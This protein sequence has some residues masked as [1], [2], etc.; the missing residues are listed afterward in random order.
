M[1][2]AQM[3]YLKM[4]LRKRDKRNNP[5]E[6]ENEHNL[7]EEKKE[8]GFSQLYGKMKPASPQ[9]EYPRDYPV[10]N[11]T[12]QTEALYQEFKKTGKISGQNT[13]FPFRNNF[14]YEQFTK[15]LK[16]ERG[17]G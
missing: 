7:A 1:T 17:N 13:G 4:M 10:Q 12:D 9:K 8:G 2:N 5:D 3:Q 16:K 6:P 14:L 11:T 15:R